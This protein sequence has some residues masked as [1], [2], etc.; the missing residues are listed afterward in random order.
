MQGTVWLYTIRKL[1]TLCKYI[2]MDLGKHIAFYH[3]ELAQLW[4]CPVMWCT[5]WKGTAQDCIDHMR[6]MHK[7]PLSVN[8]A[9]LSKFFPAWT[10]TREL[11][12]DMLMPSI[13]GV[14]ID[15]L[16]FSRIGL[17]LC[18]RYWLIS[19]TGSHAAF[20][21]TY[22]RRLRAF[23]DES[24]SAV[25]RRLHR[26][27]AQELVSRVVPPTD[28]PASVQPRSTVRHQTVSRSRRPHRLKGVTNSA[29]GPESSC[30]L[31]AEMSSVQALMDLA[32][33]RWRMGLVRFIRRGRLRPIRRRRRLQLS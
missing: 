24:D 26:R 18:H 9:N 2:Q 8:A 31:P 25:V 7:V 23:L 4:R 32:G 14:V 20:R 12:A 13:S 21:G 3:L 10:V 16:L 17:S 29:G 11:W 27:L 19:Q 15:T 6:R 33:S 22:L 28:S 1:Y 30:R 5:V